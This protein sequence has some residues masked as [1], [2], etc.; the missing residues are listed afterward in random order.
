[1]P[2]EDDYTS[3]VDGAAGHAAYW[4]GESRNDRYADADPDGP[5]GPA[6]CVLCL[7]YEDDCT[8]DHGVAIETFSR[9][10]THIAKRDHKDGRIKKGDTYREIVTGGYHMG[11]QERQRFG[12]WTHS[13]HRPRWIHS[14]K[15]L[16]ARAN[17]AS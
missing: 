6:Q 3:T 5:E 2:R 8:C 17:P 9:T 15:I 7:Q 1:M 10:Y 11:K 14:H 4:F 16:I 13:S 12:N